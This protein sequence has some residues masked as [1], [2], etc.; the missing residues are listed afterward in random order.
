MVRAW[1]GGCGYDKR[2]AAIASAVRKIVFVKSP[3]GTPLEHQ[4]AFELFRS[5]LETDG[6]EYWDNKLTRAGFTVLQA[7]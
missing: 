1:A 4:Q 2:S 5:T 6:G 7:V 3:A